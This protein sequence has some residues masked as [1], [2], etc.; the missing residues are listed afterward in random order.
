MKL[1]L[2][3]VLHLFLMKNM[4][5]G[6]LNNLHS[7]VWTNRNCVCDCGDV[8]VCVH[9]VSCRHAKAESLR[10]CLDQIFSGLNSGIVWPLCTRLKIA[11]APRHAF[12][13]PSPSDLP[14]TGTLTCAG[15]F[16]PYTGGRDEAHG[17]VR[18]II[19]GLKLWLNIFN[20]WLSSKVTLSSTS[21]A[22]ILQRVQLL[23]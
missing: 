11:N 1:L 9:P 19:L 14:P 12:V 21:L 10:L 4:F 5:K 23:M 13:L 8:C 16:L 22:G 18:R 20:L 2:F 15:N 3:L 7:C 6:H 17:T